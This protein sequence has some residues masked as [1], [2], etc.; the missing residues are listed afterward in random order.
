MFVE[1]N[2]PSTIQTQSP[3]SKTEHKRHRRSSS[4]NSFF[5]LSS[6]RAL[7]L[8]GEIGIHQVRPRSLTHK[9]KNVFQPA[10]IFWFANLLFSLCILDLSLICPAKCSNSHSKQTPI[11]AYPSPVGICC[12]METQK[13]TLLVPFFL[14]LPLDLQQVWGIVSA[15]LPTLELLL[16]SRI[17]PFPETVKG[18]STESWAKSGGVR[19]TYERQS[20]QNSYDI[21]EKL[22]LLYTW[23]L[24]RPTRGL[25]GQHKQ[26]YLSTRTNTQSLL[27]QSV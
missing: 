15:T 10:L 6:R 7:R 22:G 1:T 11:P 26:Q 9:T 13:H 2:A 27:S 21:D 3:R 18:P 16:F 5:W 14:F 25:E 23:S 8:A 4:K 20:I 12:V 19:S 24:C 17:I